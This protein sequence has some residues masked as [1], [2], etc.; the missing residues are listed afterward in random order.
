MAKEITENEN[1]E[2]AY[3]GKKSNVIYR[4]QLEYV[5]GKLFWTAAL[6]LGAITIYAS[7]TYLVVKQLKKD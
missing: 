7:L 6:I 3:T 2:S 4:D 1:Y 5:G